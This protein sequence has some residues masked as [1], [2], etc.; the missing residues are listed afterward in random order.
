M[1]I[2]VLT[3]LAVIFASHPAL[4]EHQCPVKGRGFNSRRVVSLFAQRVDRI[5][6]DYDI[7][8]EDDC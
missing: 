3:C 5:V 4:D 8:I 7:A 1:V 2:H 6:T